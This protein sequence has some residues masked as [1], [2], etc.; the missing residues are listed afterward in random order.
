MGQHK[1]VQI[2]LEFVKG[3]VH[4]LGKICPGSDPDIADMIYYLGPFK[5][6]QCT[7]GYEIW[8][9]F[10]FPMLNHHWQLCKY[11]P[12]LPCNCSYNAFI[13]ENLYLSGNLSFSSILISLRSGRKY[14]T[15]P[16]VE[17]NIV[18][19]SCSLPDQTVIII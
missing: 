2:C 8:D 10:N 1:S 14:W 9:N 18:L 12:H 13:Q 4:I 19:E 17:L 15:I 6:S 11:G 3:A 16:K 7:I 5:F